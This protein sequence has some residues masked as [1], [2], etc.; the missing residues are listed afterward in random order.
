VVDMVS[1]TKSNG[2]EGS[3]LPP[4]EPTSPR[5]TRRSGRRSLPLVQTSAPSSSTPKSSQSNSPGHE[6]QVPT[7]YQNPPQPKKRKG[8]KDEAEEGSLLD[9]KPSKREDAKG[10]REKLTVDTKSTTN[11]QQGKGRNKRKS[12]AAKEEKM[13]ETPVEEVID[14]HTV[15]GDDPDGRTRCICGNTTGEILHRLR[16]YQSMD[17]CSRGSRGR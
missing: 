1:T 7:P 5:E 3:M 12:K 6:E 17:W 11:N 16:N 9:Y 14:Q 10:R 4:V 15:D 2:S 8:V 13:V